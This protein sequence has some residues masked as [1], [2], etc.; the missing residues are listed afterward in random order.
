MGTGWIAERFVTALRSHTQ[1]VPYAVGARTPGRAAEF[2]ARHGMESAYSS[3]SE[4]LGDPSV[5]VVYVATPHNHHLEAALSAIAAGKHLVVEKPLG[6]NADEARRIATAASEAGVYCVEAL[7]TLFLPKF[8]VLRQ[9][10][11]DGAIGEPSAVMADLG[12]WF[13]DSHRIRRAELAGG[14][15]LDLGTY[16]VTL[17]TWVLGEPADVVALATRADEVDA[18]FG[19]VLRTSTGAVASLFSSIDSLTPTTAVIAGTDGELVLDGPFY[20]P[21]RFTARDRRGTELVWDEPAVAH[22]GLHYEAAAVARDIAQGRTESPIR[23]LTASIRT[24]RTM[25]RITLAGD[26]R[27]EP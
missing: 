14:V 5:D 21:G 10:I 6:V 27:S 18:Q 24:L 8:D 17:A 3:Y 23:P 11:D 7:W 20:M 1:Q 26:P 13:A 25:D 12:E 15:M 2:A 4:L 22:E 9:L 16:P 19:A